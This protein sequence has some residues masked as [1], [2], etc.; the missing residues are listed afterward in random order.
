MG[1]EL[2]FR[3]LYWDGDEG[4]ELVLLDQTAL[5][6]EERYVRLKEVSGVWDA[7]R[8]LVVRGAPAI[9]VAAAYGLYLG[10][11]D[12]DEEDRLWERLIK[13]RD[14]LLSS[15]PTA[16][17]LRNA[18]ERM[19]RAARREK[20]CGARQIK[21]TLFKTANELFEEDVRLCEEMGRYGAALLPDDATVLTIC[22]AGALATCGIGTALAVVYTAA[23][24]GRRI[25]V[26]ACETRPLLQGARLTSWEL[27]RV[28]IPVT[29]ICDN[30]VGWLLSNHRVDA[31][32]VGADRIARNG[33]FAN[34]I[35]T[36]QLA[37]LA[38]RHRVPFYTVAPSTSFDL[39]A[40]DGGAIPIEQR[41]PDE[42]RSVWG[43]LRIT[44]ENI[45]VYN[46]AFD[47]TPAE[48]V[49]AVVWEGGVMRPP[50][51]EAITAALGENS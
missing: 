18:L 45:S 16:V 48:L 42:V 20:G 17:N 12:L 15:R 22:N 38:R 25:K 49:T 26:I 19:E 1:V 9:G 51:E 39:R 23:S 46:P 43:R 29:L 34:K 44:L 50:L 30:M 2:P 27:T 36:Y 13:V 41:Q 32:V 11:R 47:V 10:V 37:V 24:Q 3:T 21:H 33:D 40:P 31:C 6:D 28:G 14:Y 7:I 4:G 8:R 35:G 5:P